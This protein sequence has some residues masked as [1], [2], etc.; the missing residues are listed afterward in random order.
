MAKSIVEPLKSVRETA[1]TMTRARFTTGCSNSL[2]SFSVSGDRKTNNG[3]WR[4]SPQER[5]AVKAPFYIDIHGSRPT[6]Q[7]FAGPSLNAL[8]GKIFVGVATRAQCVKTVDPEDQNRDKPA[9]RV[10]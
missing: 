8:L 6:Q 3:S 5:A 7:R 1:S 2:E 10:L 4:T 9:L